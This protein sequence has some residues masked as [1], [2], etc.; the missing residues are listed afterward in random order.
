M[1]NISALVQLLN[2]REGSAWA[3]VGKLPGGYQRGAY[4][5]RGPGG[6]RAVLK[7]Q[8]PSADAGLL[9]A[10]AQVIE[11][12]RLAGWPT[13]RWLAF[14]RLPDGRE[15]IVREFIAGETPAAFGEREFALL[16]RANRTQA[17]LHPDTDRD[18]S[19]Y[20]R[21]AVFEPGSRPTVRMSELPETAELLRRLRVEAADARDKPL[22]RSDL[23]HGDFVLLNVLVRQGTAYLID[24]E[25]AGKGTRAYD[26]ATLLMESSIG[27]DPGRPSAAN[28]RGLERECLAL[29]GRSGLRLCVA[30]RMLD[31]LA[32]G[33]D[34]WAAD[35]PSCVARCHAFLDWLTSG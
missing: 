23:V 34:H 28:A 8:P 14:G 35:V 27:G 13:P 6:A 33:L 12:A 22:P 20:I 4:E 31:L 1:E 15:Y 21:S 5:L 2:A 17:D 7:W 25:Y 11:Q 18:W 26:L 29:V 32:F 16:L 19:A 9:R 3:F 10:T 30:A 24:A